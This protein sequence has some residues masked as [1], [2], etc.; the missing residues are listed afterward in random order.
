MPAPSMAVMINE[1]I[2]SLPLELPEESIIC[3]PGGV[4]NDILRCFLKFAISTKG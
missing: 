3:M 1:T 4:I 2:H